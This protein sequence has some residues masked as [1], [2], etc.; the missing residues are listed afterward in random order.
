MA[1]AFDEKNGRIAGDAVRVV[2]GVDY[3]P[4]WLVAN[5]A[6]SQNGVLAYLPG[7]GSLFSSRLTWF[8]SSGKF[9][10]TVG[11][12]GSNR[13]PR[14]SPD[15]R[16]LVFSRGV[17]DPTNRLIHDLWQF[18]LERNVPT[19]LTF[20]GDEINMPSAW[21]P[22]SR[23]VAFSSSRKNNGILD[24]YVRGTDGPGADELLYESA[25]NKAATGFSPDGKIL[26]FAEAMGPQKGLDVWALPMT[27]DRR[28][29]PLIQTPFNESCAVFSPDGRWIAY[30]S[31]DSGTRQVYVQ[32]FPPT[33]QPIRLSTTSGLGPVWV[34]NGTRIVY[35]TVEPRFMAVNVTT[36]SG[37]LQ[38][39]VARELFT[40]RR[41]SS[42]A[43]CGDFDVDR[44]GERF[45][46]AARPQEW[47][48]A[49]IGI[50]VNWPSMLRRR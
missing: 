16:R 42:N 22:D 33:G 35:G 3:Y 5:F 18:D 48:D 21:S 27:G 50:I 4:N 19:Q 24:L 29:F 39:G 13:H 46:L 40:A 36:S 41:H 28:P 32:P 6:M 9:L 2:E 10:D 20:D 38:A 43:F 25:R 45:L 30:V 7:R 11:E 37:M 14:L 34:A 12:L 44:S 8:D 49:T 23:R 31:D 17:L 26:L 47:T 15:G 1:Q